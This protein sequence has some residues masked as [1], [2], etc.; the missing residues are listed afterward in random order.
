MQC[1]C[2][3]W[4][5]IC[6]FIVAYSQ[7]WNAP[8]LILKEAASWDKTIAIITRFLSKAREDDKTDVI[9]AIAF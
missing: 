7:K 8:D 1:M 2:G 3:L 4:L 9:I 5:V 6:N